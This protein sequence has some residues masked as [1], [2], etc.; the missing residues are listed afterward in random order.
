MPITTGLTRTNVQIDRL[1]RT[2][3]DVLTIKVLLLDNP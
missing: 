2:I 3:I 1:N